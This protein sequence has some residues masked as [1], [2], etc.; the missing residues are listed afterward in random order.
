MDRH[1]SAHK[2]RHD[3]QRPAMCSFT[4]ISHSNPSLHGR[5]AVILYALRILGAE[6]LSTSIASI[7]VFLRVEGRYIRTEPVKVRTFASGEEPAIKFSIEKSD[8]NIILEKWR[9]LFAIRNKALGHGDVEVGSAVF[10]F[11][12]SPAGARTAD[13]LTIIITDNF[14]R[15]Y[16]SVHHLR[17]ANLKTLDLG[18]TI[19]I[20][21]K[22]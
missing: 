9:D 18:A 1:A 19:D 22:S 17:E 6:Q 21:E 4:L 12:A 8:T 13:R 5:H 11:D 7:E 20:S 15:K 3:I 10:A 14:G 2:T 16:K